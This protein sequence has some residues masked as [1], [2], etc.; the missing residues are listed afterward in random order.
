M[1]HKPHKNNVVTGQLSK[2]ARRTLRKRSR[3]LS[4]NL[5][6]AEQKKLPKKVVPDLANGWSVTRVKDEQTGLVSFVICGPTKGGDTFQVSTP[7][8]QCEEWKRVRRT[9]R[10]YEAALPGQVDLDLEFIEALFDRAN[11][12]PRIATSMPGFTDAGKG[13]VLGAQT[14]GDAVDRYHWLGDDYSSLGQTSGTR[15][16]W[17]E[18]GKLLQHS[19]FATIAVLTVLASPVPNYVLWR[20][21]EDPRWRPALSETAIINIAG[22]SSSGKT[23]ASSVA[24]SLSGDPYDRAKWDFSRRGLEEYLHTRNEV[25]AV[26]DDVEKHTGESMN[27]R[28]A[29]TTVTQSLPDGASKVVSRV[30][31]DHG[32]PRLTWSEFG[33]SSSPLPVQEIAHDGG[34]SRSRGEQVRLID[35]CVPPSERGGI[36]DTPP[37]GTHNVAE[38]SLGVAKKMERGIALHYG[39]V[40]PAWIEVLLAENR[41]GTLLASQDYFV[42][43][44]A[45][46]GSGYD[47]RFASKFGLLY[48]VGRLAV[49]HDVLPLAAEWPGIAVYRGYRNALLAAQGEAALTAKALARLI[50]TLKEQN[51][52]V[53][54]TEEPRSRPPQLN[55]RHVGV[56]LKHK[57][58]QVIGVL[59]RAL[60]QLAGDRYIARLVIK[61]LGRHGAY[62]GGQGHAGTSQ[63]GQPLLIKGTLVQKPRFWLFKTKALVALEKAMD[64]REQHSVSGL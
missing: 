36:F 31:R 50:S 22:E 27:L 40:T 54:I 28:R 13:F 61:L 2:K 49:K 3:P 44:A 23:L 7:A 38:F 24:A 33:L 62:A 19:S 34:W 39:H 30:A 55:D 52:L 63:I 60:V 42:Q 64:S 11:T 59:D 18:V 35:L 37:P 4:L 16:G 15:E 58:E 10:A 46:A 5:A 48:A 17:N 41:A 21:S 12:S 32:L 9:L 53:P 43:T 8:E 29:I 51:R 6:A 26:F 45:R 1:F 47:A 14:L 56:S 57:G 20:K 25:G